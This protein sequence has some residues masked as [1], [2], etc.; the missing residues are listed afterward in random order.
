M[1]II[2]RSANHPV[3]RPNRAWSIVV[4]AYVDIFT[5]APLERDVC[6]FRD[7]HPVPVPRL[8][9]SLPIRTRYLDE[10]GPANILES[11]RLLSPEARSRTRHNRVGS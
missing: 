2:P 7:H 10:L 11:L 4:G 3:L 9:T 6:L 1:V 8:C 5:S